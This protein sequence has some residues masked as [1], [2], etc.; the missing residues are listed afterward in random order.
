MIWNIG[1]SAKAR[2]HASDWQNPWCFVITYVPFA[3]KLHVKYGRKYGTSRSEVSIIND[4]S[5]AAGSLKTRQTIRCV[6]MA[7]GALKSINVFSEVHLF[8]VC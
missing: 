7:L 5:P 4:S 6:A 2:K 3:V 8:L 1:C